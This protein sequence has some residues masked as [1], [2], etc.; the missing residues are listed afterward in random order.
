MKKAIRK[1]F[2]ELA[3]FE[4][5][6]YSEIFQLLFQTSLYLEHSMENDKSLNAEKKV[7]LD[8]HI[9]ALIALQ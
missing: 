5:R 6:T 3:S 7:V 9:T 8:F 2:D 4:P 1:G